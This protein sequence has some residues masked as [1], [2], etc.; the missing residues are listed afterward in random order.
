[1]FFDE[2]GT[3]K[4]T[5]DSELIIPMTNE[6]I[7]ELEKGYPAECLNPG[8]KDT[9]RCTSCGKHFWIKME[10]KKCSRTAMCSFRNW[11]INLRTSNG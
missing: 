8:M 5:E 9:Y 11:D 3:E 7:L 10:K 1:M 6:H 2:K 4:V